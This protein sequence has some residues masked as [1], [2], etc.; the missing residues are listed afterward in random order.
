[1]EWTREGG[2][3]FFSSTVVSDEP[4][5]SYFQLLFSPRSFRDTMKH[6]I[7]Q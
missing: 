5:V 4:N 1:M 7:G 6:Y 3:L 2:C